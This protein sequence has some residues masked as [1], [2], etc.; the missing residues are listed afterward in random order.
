MRDLA[1]TEMM[2]YLAL[3]TVLCGCHSVVESGP[4]MKSD[5]NWHFADTG[6]AAADGRAGAEARTGADAADGPALRVDALSD[7]WDSASLPDEQGGADPGPP[8][9]D[10]SPDLQ[11]DG[12]VC[13]PLAEQ[14]NGQ[15]DDCDG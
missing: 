5:S 13:L 12:V 6:T 2:W 9:P 15:D 7:G 11:G 8:S 4:S 1:T 14:C 10:L 3:L